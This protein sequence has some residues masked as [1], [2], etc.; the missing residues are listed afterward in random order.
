M[1][2]RCRTRAI[3]A[4]LGLVD[5]ERVADVGAD[6]DVVD[7]EQV[8]FVEAGLRRAR[9]GLPVNLVAGLDEDAPVARIDQ[10]AAR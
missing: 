2:G 8:E 3:L 6:V 9:R 7:V 4:G 1:T 10:V 5:G